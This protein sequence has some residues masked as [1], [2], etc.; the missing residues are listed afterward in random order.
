VDVGNSLVITVSQSNELN[1]FRSFEVRQVNDGADFG[2]SQ[3]DFDELRQ[4]FWQA[5]NFDL[6]NNVRAPPF[7]TGA[8]SLMKCTGTMAVSFWPA[9]TRTKSA[10]ITWPLAG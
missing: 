4:V 10:C 5:G 8:S 7:F 6:G 2:V 9:T 1:A 3:V